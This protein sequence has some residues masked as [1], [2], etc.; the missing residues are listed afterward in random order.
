MGVSD[1]RH[2]PE[3]ADGHAA[4]LGR[5]VGLA[6]LHEVRVHLP[7]DGLEADTHHLGQDPHHIRHTVDQHLV[8]LRVLRIVIFVSLLARALLG[9]QHQ[10]GLIDLIHVLL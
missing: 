7:E 9:H 8:V 5:P 4:V 6:E 2:L 3:A 10:G 1:L